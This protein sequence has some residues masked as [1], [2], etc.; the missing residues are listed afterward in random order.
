MRFILSGSVLAS[1]AA[2]ALFCDAQGQTRVHP[3]W[4]WALP[5]SP[6]PKNQPPDIAAT[7]KRF[8]LKITPIGTHKDDVEDAINKA[9]RC[10]WRAA[11]V[12]NVSTPDL[13]AQPSNDDQII[14]GDL[15]ELGACFS[16]IHPR[17]RFQFDAA[18]I[19]KDVSVRMYDSSV[20]TVIDRPQSASAADQTE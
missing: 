19:L 6:P 15:V 12:D 10:E 17:V 14:E 9:F 20:I 13:R 16:S 4:S 2:V 3:I 1:L 8:V 7:A 11:T 18:G 5:P